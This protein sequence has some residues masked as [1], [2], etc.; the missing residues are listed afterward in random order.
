MLKDRRILIE[1]DL[2]KTQAEAAKLYLS[3]VTHDGDVYS[4]EYQLL[5]NRIM[6]LQFDLN[7]VN[8]LIAKGHE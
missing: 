3:I 4:S 8:D 2:A 6:N 5:K 1:Q 7:M